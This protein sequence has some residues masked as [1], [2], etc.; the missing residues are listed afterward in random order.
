MSKTVASGVHADGMD[1]QQRPDP[2]VPERPRPRSYSARYKAQMLDEYERLDKAAKGALLRREGLYTSLISEWRKQRDHG[3][4]EALAKPAGRSPRPR[5]GP[6][7]PGERPSDRRA[8]P[9]PQGD[10]GPGKTLGA[11]GGARHRQRPD[12]P[13]RDEV[14]D[15]AIAQLAPHVG[16][17]GACAAVGEAQARWYRRHRQSPPPP[18]PERVRA[19]QP[20]ALSEVE[21]KELR[22]TLNSD[23]HVDEAPATVYAKLLDQ[24]VYLASVPTMYRAL[25]DHDEV[26]ER[27]RQ[28]TPGSQEARTAGHQT[29]RDLQL[30]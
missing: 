13:G 14:I 5:D 29:Q 28:D 30:G 2:E 24:G 12:R 9:R 7:A 11:V 22:A 1:N 18:K 19:P 23:E 20:R 27:R 21:R 17:R 26:H 4:L 25:R 15:A 6:A 8:G 16:T 3:A 10:R